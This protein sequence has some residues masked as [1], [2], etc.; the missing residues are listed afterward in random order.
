MRDAEIPINEYRTLKE[1][2]G[3]LM[4]FLEIVYNAKRLH[5]AWNYVPLVSFEETYQ[6]QQKQP[7][8]SAS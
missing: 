1:A 2:W 5:S 4:H 6:Q 8:I 3:N 7:I